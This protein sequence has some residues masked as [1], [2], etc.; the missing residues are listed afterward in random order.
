MNLYSEQNMMN[1]GFDI[2]RFRCPLDNP[3]GDAW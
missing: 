2:M 1:S 3:S